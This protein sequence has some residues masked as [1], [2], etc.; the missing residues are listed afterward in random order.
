MF[1]TPQHLAFEAVLDALFSSVDVLAPVLTFLEYGA[2]VLQPFLEPLLLKPIEGGL[3]HAFNG[4]HLMWMALQL[5]LGSLSALLTWL[6]LYILTA[7]LG[8]ARIQN[9]GLSFSTFILAPFIFGLIKPHLPASLI[10]D[11]DG[12]STPGKHCSLP[13]MD[14][15]GTA[16]QIALA[17]PME[18]STGLACPGPGTR[19]GVSAPLCL[20]S[21]RCGASAPTCSPSPS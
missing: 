2:N 1:A 13:S 17:Y 5:L 18:G 4:L 21:T 8:E 9:T 16:I 12:T 6:A 14:F 7:A 11:P 19:S 10:V 15:E 3:K 20:P